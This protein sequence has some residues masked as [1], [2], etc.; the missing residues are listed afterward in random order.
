MFDFYVLVLVVGEMLV[1][2][3]EFLFGYCVE[4]V[5]DFV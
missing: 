1:E 5:F 4:Y 2:G 3:V